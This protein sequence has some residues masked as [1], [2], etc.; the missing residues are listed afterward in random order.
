MESGLNVLDF[1]V[2]KDAVYHDFDVTGFGYKITEIPRMETS[3]F[4]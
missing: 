1:V 3:C 4:P 2:S